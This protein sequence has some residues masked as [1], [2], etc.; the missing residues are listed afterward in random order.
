MKLCQAILAR[1]RT[2]GNNETECYFRNL[3][4]KK[5]NAESGKF[6]DHYYQVCFPKY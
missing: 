5:R 6:K 2:D 1:V 3:S 4:F